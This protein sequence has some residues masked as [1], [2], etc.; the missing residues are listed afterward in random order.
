MFQNQI[1]QEKERNWNT[2]KRQKIFLRLGLPRLSDQSTRKPLRK[3]GKYLDA[4]KEKF[5]LVGFPTEENAS[6]GVG[7]NEI[8]ALSSFLTII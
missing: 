2:K 5:L 6:G 7:G 8:D 1:N 3:R 4:S